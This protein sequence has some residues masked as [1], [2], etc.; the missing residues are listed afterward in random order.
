MRLGYLVPQF[1]AQTHAF[2]W[3]EVQALRALGVDVQLISTRKPK[4]DCPHGFSKTAAA[5]THYLLPPPPAAW[6]AT[7]RQSPR[8][9]A[10]TARYVWN[11]KETPAPRRITGPLWTLAASELTRICQ[12]HDLDHLHVHSCGQAAHLAALSQ[13]LGAPPYSLTLHGDLPVYGPNQRSK[14]RSAAFVSVVTRA[15]QHQVNQLVGLPLEKL[16]IIPMGVDL[17]HFTPFDTQRRTPQSF[18]FL[19]VA[20]LQACKGHRYALEAIA[21]LPNV[22][23]RIVGHGPDRAALESQAHA[24]KID[25]RVVFTG[26]LDE[27]D[28]LKE[29][30]RAD[31][32][33]LPSVGLGEAAP[34]SVMEAMACGK[35]VIASIIGG[36]PDM[37]DHG[38]E[39]HLVN[40]GDI[41]ELTSA[42]RHLATHP[43]NRLS[44]GHAAR[45][46]ALS[47]FDHHANAALLLHQLES[48]SATQPTHPLHEPVA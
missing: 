47:Q 32:F 24:L 20:R 29:L 39:G 4:T 18:T 28:V 26:P 25:D 37:I 22:H 2:F 16:P 9:L 21:K 14:M 7:F 36:T 34:V 19:T 11:L 35:P 17:S 41:P 33:L 48:S 44:M 31:A 40:Q 13:H 10:N 5:Q 43:Q 38:V 15:L 46:R 45:Q 23:Y 6:R 42:M 3:R 8:A 30:H 1:P 12:K 27:N